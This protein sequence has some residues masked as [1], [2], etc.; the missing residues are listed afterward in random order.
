MI[1]LERLGRRK[2]EAKAGLERAFGGDPPVGG[3]VSGVGRAVAS[4]AAET[5]AAL[6]VVREGLGALE[7]FVQQARAR[8]QHC[9]ILGSPGAPGEVYSRVLGKRDGF[10]DVRLLDSSAPDAVRGGLRGFAP[11]QTL[12]IVTA[13][14][15]ETRALYRYFRA[16]VEQAAVAKEAGAQ[17]VAVGPEGS[18]LLAFALEEGF[19]RS[20][21]SP[22]SA[23]G[24]SSF[25]PAALLGLDLHKLVSEAERIAADPSPVRLGAIT[26]GLAA[27]S[28]DKLTLLFSKNLAPLGAW[29]SGLVATRTAGNGRGVIPIAGEGAGRKQ[30]Y[31]P[32]RLFASASFAAEKQDLS[33]LADS[34]HPVLQWQLE[35]REGLAGEFARWEIAAGVMGALLGAPHAPEPALAEAA[36]PEPAL[37][38]R[39]L[40]LFAEPGHA[41]LLQRA[42]RTLGASAAESPAG[43]IA[44]H[45]ALADE[46]D[47]AALVAFLPHDLP[48]E[49]EL[50]AAQTSLRDAT[51]MACALDFGPRCSHGT[52][53][54]YA[55]GPASGLF[56][57]LSAPGGEDLPIPGEPH[58]FASLWKAQI[59]AQVGALAARRV[60]RVHAED[61][62]TGPL[63]EELR[64]AI[65]LLSFK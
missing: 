48:L 20:F 6:A 30:A 12:F 42:A 31:G 53:R 32:D 59:Q 51:R 49:E 27:A 17:F 52:G 63:L 28:A 58:G 16:Q 65:R 4:A 34:G 10:L 33:W 11:E 57:V 5:L 61:G 40:A 14:D 7:E 44:A 23:L 19:L 29:V 46:G 13:L 43:W 50:A 25:L 45:F 22:A 9:L 64:A 39:G 56:L 55:D 3:A 26:A 8:F 24:Y 41:E 21:E 2:G 36:A 1:V 54:V 60:L 15:L 35:T 18:A 47:Y 62:K 38:A 37:R